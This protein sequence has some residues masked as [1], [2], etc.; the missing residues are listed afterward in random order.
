MGA[1][2]IEISMGERGTQLT[3]SVVWRFGKSEVNGIEIAWEQAGPAHGE[4]LLLIMGL[5][6]QAIHWPEALCADLISRGFRVI[7]FDNRDIGRSASVNRGVRFDLLKDSLRVK[8]GLR[9]RANYTLHDLADDTLGLMDALELPRVHL[10]GFSMGGMVAQIL[11]ARHPLRVKSLNALM[12]STNHPWLPPPAMP[13]LRELFGKLP[14]NADRDL[15]VGNMVKMQRLLQGRGYPT[16]DQALFELSERAFERGHRLGG[17]MRQTHGIVATGSLEGLT[18]EIVVP[19][20]VIHGSEDPMLRPVGAKRIAKLVRGA[21][22][23]LIRGLGH[24][25][26][27]A[28]LPRI[29][30]LVGAN[31]A[32]A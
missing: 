31:A 18:S 2:R 1:D 28:V 4:P 20:Q 19:T 11:A 27:Q 7:R 23:D 13:V 14:P 32:R 5:S 24:D 8:A 15:L 22:F 26:P 25:L 30:E 16:A 6:W 21:R 9:V 29:V 12:T 17:V 3:P 10:A